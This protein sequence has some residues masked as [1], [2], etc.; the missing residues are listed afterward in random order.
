MTDSLA[1][2]HARVL[3]SIAEV[4]AAEFVLDRETSDTLDPRDSLGEVRAAVARYVAARRALA[5]DIREYCSEAERLA[6]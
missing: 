6:E 4:A 5:Y 2:R 1:T 3:A